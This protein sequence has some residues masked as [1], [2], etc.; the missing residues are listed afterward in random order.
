[1]SASHLSQENWKFLA[2]VVDETYKGGHR[3]RDQDVFADKDSAQAWIDK[4]VASGY[5][6]RGWVADLTPPKRAPVWNTI[7]AF[8]GRLAKKPLDA[9]QLECLN[10]FMTDLSKHPKTPEIE[11]IIENHH[12]RSL[13]HDYRSPE[14]CPKSTLAAHLE[15]AGLHEMARNTY[16][17]LY[18]F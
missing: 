13:Y 4:R 1:M 6:L 9:D 18:D 16:H 3:G 2:T 11:A 15:K 10:R 7:E 17:G 5:Y 12:K 8:C 14:P